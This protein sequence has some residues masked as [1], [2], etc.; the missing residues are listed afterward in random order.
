MNTV[1][2]LPVVAVALVMIGACAL[3]AAPAS[4]TVEVDKPGVTISPTLWGI[5]FEDINLSA[6]GGIYPEFVRNRS[7]EDSDQPDH[8]TLSK[9]DGDKSEMAIDSSRPIDPMNRQSLRVK[10]DGP[11][12]LINKGYWGMN[13][14][15]GAS[16][17]VR[18]AARAA[19]GFKGPIGVSLQK[20]DGSGL[21]KGEITS[22]TD[23]W[24]GFSLELTAT[25]TD[26]KAQ[27]S[28]AVSG[29]G[30]LWLD[31]VCVAPAKTWKNHGLRP[32]LCEMLAG[33]KPAFVRFPGGCWVEGDDM[34]HMYH[35]KNTIGEFWHRKPLWNIWQYWATHGLGYHEYLQMCEDLDA[36]PLFVINVGMSHKE[37]IPMDQMGQWV[38]D[39]LDA[40]EYANGPADSVWGGLRAKNGHPE[41]FHLKYIE[42]GNENGGPPYQ[43]R[44][45]LFHDAIRA[46]YPK[47]V[48]ISDQPT[49][50][51]PSDIVDEHYYSNPEFFMQQAGRYDTYDR[52]GPKIY[53]GEYAVTQ[54]CGQGNLRGAIGEAAFMTGMERNSDVVV[55]ASYAPLFANV[56]YK[57]WNPDLICFDSS[58]VYGLPSYYVQKMFAENRGAVVLP[59]AVSSPL[60]EQGS[61][62]ERRNGGAVGVGTW[63]TQAEFKDIKVT[64]GDK[65]LFSCDF[66]DGTKG[67]RLLRGNWTVQDG[68]L[69]Q[70][71]N[72][73]NVRAIAGD[74]SWTDYTY[75]L[76]A[77]KLGGAEGFLILFNVRDENRKS[78]WNLGGWG[79]QRHAIEMGG[80]VGNDAPGSIETGRWYDIRI[81]VS[82][83]TIKCYL[84]DKLIHDV[85]PPVLKSLYASASRAKDTGEVILKVVNT[86]KAEL[87]TDIKL[88]GVKS[89]QRP[90]KATVLTSEN[91]TDENSL[92]EPTKVAP[93]TKTIGVKAPSFQHAFPGNSVTIL[94]LRTE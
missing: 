5:F 26:P 62:D 53:V 92:T 20:A 55:M 73:D 19:D 40:I 72:A 41:P 71:S 60:V 33:L 85:T 94:R 24:K 28:L 38:Q 7:F 79:N 90:A 8:W 3:H 88:S 52:K 66:A 16:Y 84:D 2:S 78:W 70:N 18:L 27:L 82:G 6:D 63:L 31:M 4:L 75:T 12:T 61:T 74:R 39:A 50:R 37:H 81:E 93:V 48:L 32:D 65:T 83:K 59:V 11:V 56:N 1:R 86:S 15:K 69:R 10:V 54:G 34:A 14:V 45:V 9:A 35:W 87:S 25:D 47:M 13:V 42:I 77:R 29:K 17:Q 36:E 21:A 89:V 43:E 76:K 23:Q 58:R 44:Y 30:T 46:R 49:T 80:L 91:G 68:A 51:R 22:L 64:K 67:W 57:R